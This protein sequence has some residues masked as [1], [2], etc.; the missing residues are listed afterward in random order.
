MPCYAVFLPLPKHLSII[1]LKF[2]FQ[3]GNHDNASQHDDQAMA[4]ESTTAETRNYYREQ[5]AQ[6]FATTRV[7]GAKASQGPTRAV[8]ANAITK[9]K[10]T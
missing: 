9:T 4:S 7:F 1:N 10:K 8:K 6:I 2:I 3:S 5:A